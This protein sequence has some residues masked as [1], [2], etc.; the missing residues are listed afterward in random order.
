MNDVL[1][2]PSRRTRLTLAT[3]S[4]V[5]GLAVITTLDTAGDYPRLGEGPGL[6]VDEMFNV[7]EGYRLVRATAMWMAGEFHW[8]EVFGERDDLGPAAPAG[9]H[10]ADHPPLG[11]FALGLAH[12]AVLAVAPPPSRGLSPFVPTAARVGSALAFAWLVYVVGRAAAGWYG[13][14]AGVSAALALV[15]M[16][17]LFAHAHLAS[18]EMMITLA[19]A[20]T[21]ISLAE[22]WSRPGG[23]RSRDALVPGLLLGLALLTKIQAVLLGPPVAIWALWQWRHHALKPLAIWAAV[24]ALVFLVGWPWLWIDPL[25]HLTEYFARTTQRAS[26]SVWYLGIKS[27]DNQVAWHYPLVMFVT[28]VPLGLHILAT[29]GLCSRRWRWWKDPRAVLLTACTAFPV[30]LFSVPGLSVYDGVRLF[31]V[32]FPLWAVLVGRGTVVA[33][34]WLSTKLSAGAASGLLAVVFLGQAWG[35][36]IMHPCG[37]GFY[38]LAVGGPAG[39]ERLGLEPTYWGDSL[40]RGF[41]ATVAERVPENETIAVFPSL[42]PVQWTE[43]LRHARIWGEKPPRLAL[44]GTPAAAGARF[45]MIFRRKADLPE[46]LRQKPPGTRSVAEVRRAGVVLAALYQQRIRA[47]ELRN[48]TTDTYTDN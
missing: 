34:D 22:R 4:L 25:D 20:A 36:V 27:P 1:T 35:L 12:E 19:Y 42:H 9:Y 37:L 47:E 21:V 29:C 28:T 15:L 39:A 2:P 44:Y 31:L 46:E 13:H 38:N 10:L 7:G 3:L 43:L 23:P 48:D 14:L 41:L 40:T 11:R 17:R 5:A 18:L 8:R 32:V 16:P 6:T 24:G 30:L 45:I 26:L 33:Y